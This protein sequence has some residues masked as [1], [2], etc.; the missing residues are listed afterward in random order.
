LGRGIRLARQNPR[1]TNTGRLN[2]F[3][4]LTGGTLSE[5][6]LAARGAAA[7]LVEATPGASS[8]P[9]SAPSIDAVL[10]Q[11]VALMMSMPSFRHTFLSDLEWMVL[12]PILLQQYRLIRVEGH[13]IGF[14]AWASL[15]EAAEARLNGAS[16]RLAPADWRSGDR[17]WLVHLFM[18][19]GHQEA[20]LVDLRETALK[21]KTFK[22]HRRGADG[23]AVVET[24]S[25]AAAAGAG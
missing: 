13:V 2:Y 21:G 15:S 20:A 12:P 1:F 3:G 4:G 18:P 19:F 9:P 10:G 5:V 6:P 17:L 8:P 11:V 24:V 22:M 23:R 14:A 16:P 25:A 7:D